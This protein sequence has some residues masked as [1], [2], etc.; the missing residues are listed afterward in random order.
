LSFPE[1][2]AADAAW[3]PPTEQVAAISTGTDNFLLGRLRNNM[4]LLERKR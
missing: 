1:R 4:K 3:A 2:V